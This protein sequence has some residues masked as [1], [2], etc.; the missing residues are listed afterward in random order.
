MV[1]RKPPY[2]TKINVKPLTAFLED[3]WSQRPLLRNHQQV[4]CQIL[5]SHLAA[6]QIAYATRHPPSASH[7]RMRL[8]HS[9]I[10][11]LEKPECTISKV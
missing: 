7:L 10:C 8:H 1:R 11:F 4:C 3:N 6:R 5:F 2:R 9:L